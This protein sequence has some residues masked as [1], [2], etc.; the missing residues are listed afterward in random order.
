MPMISA[1]FAALL[2]VSGSSCVGKAGHGCRGGAPATA[3]AVLPDVASTDLHLVADD[4]TSGNW[5]SRVGGYTATLTG[6]VTKGFTS[7]FPGRAE[8]TGFTSSNYFVIASAAAHTIQSN[9]TTTY[10]LIVKT[11]ATFVSVGTPWG[12]FSTGATQIFNA[13]YLNNSSGDG[14]SAVYDSLATSRYLGSTFSAGYQMSAKY[15]LITLVMNVAAPRWEFYINGSTVFT[16]TTT[17][18]TLAPTTSALGIGG[19]WNNNSS[20]M[21]APW[22]GAIVE[23]MRH[24]EAFDDATVASRAAQ[25][26]ALKGY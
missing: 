21:Q 17:T 1:I 14:E 5:A 19:R 13:G 8:L 23:V 7:Q 4:Y 22:E 20:A 15:N 10:E 16:D 11:P 6:T 25:F 24:R 9:E 18:A 3:L 12:Y 2:A 26:N